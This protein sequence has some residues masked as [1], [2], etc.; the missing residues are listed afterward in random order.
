MCFTS[1]QSEQGSTNYDWLHLNV[2]VVSEY[3]IA[4]IIIRFTENRPLRPAEYHFPHISHVIS[5]CIYLEGRVIYN[6]FRRRRPLSVRNILLHS[7]FL[8]VRSPYREDH[9]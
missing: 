3:F 8:I 5:P 4:V 1:R 2:F 6:S 9:N 7:C